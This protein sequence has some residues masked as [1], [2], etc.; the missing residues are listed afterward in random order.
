MNCESCGMPIDSGKYCKYCAPG[1]R[2]KSKEQ[3]RDGWINF[4]VSNQGLSREKAEKKVDEQ[5][6][7]MPAWKDF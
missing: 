3:V 7:K 4:T 1:G 2:L 6:K 5:M